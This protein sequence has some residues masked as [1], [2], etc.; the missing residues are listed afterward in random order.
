MDRFRFR[1]WD[2]EDKIYTSFPW[3]ARAHNSHLEVDY[4]LVLEQC[5]G[6]RD[7]NRTLIFENDVLKV[8]AFPNGFANM[9]V[10]WN[11]KDCRWDLRYTGEKSPTLDMVTLV[12]ELAEA[13]EI[14]GNIHE[15]EVDK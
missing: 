9:S 12:K 1:V 11:Q 15:R 7:K 10:Y 6:L 13:S 2:P 3:F 4:P 5:T 14:I 8:P